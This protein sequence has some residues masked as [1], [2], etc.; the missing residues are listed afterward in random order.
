V[1]EDSALFS[2]H[3]ISFGSLLFF[4]YSHSKVKCY[5][6]VVLNFK[7]G[8][9]ATVTEAALCYPESMTSKKKK[10]TEKIL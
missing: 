7:T 10:S 4:S 1:D 5:L 2:L 9:S 6:T 8:Y 3:P